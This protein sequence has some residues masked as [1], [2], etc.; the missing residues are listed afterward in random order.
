MYEKTQCSHTLR[1]IGK[2]SPI[3]KLPFS[4]SNFASEIIFFTDTKNMSFLLHFACE[5]IK[6]NRQGML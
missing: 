4:R 6:Y 3:Q 2:E 1:T 5:G